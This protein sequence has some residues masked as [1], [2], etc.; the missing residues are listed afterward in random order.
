MSKHQFDNE[1]DRYGNIAFE[2]EDEVKVKKPSMYRVLLHNDDYTPM[3]FVTYIIMTIFGKTREESEYI[4]LT[5]HTSGTGL[6]GIYPF[7]IAQTKR[8]QVEQSAQSNEHPLKCTIEP[9]DDENDRK[10]TD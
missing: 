10:I 8:I 2:I 7:D 1:N 9:E 3:D 6:A 4:M 5:V